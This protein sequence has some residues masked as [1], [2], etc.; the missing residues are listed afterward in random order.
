MII[1]IGNY[2]ADK[3]ESMIRFANTLAVGLK[4]RG[5]DVQ[6]WN[7]KVVLGSC[8]SPTSLIGKWI[9]YV[10][11]W[12]LFPIFIRYRIWKL[13]NKKGKKWFHI[14]D[15]SNS[16]YLS[17]LPSHFASITCHDV[18]AIKA[19]LGYLGF[20]QTPSK[21]GKVY[22]KWILRN[23][24]NAENIATV[25]KF[26]LEQLKEITPEVNTNHCNWRVIL[27]PFNA[28]FFPLSSEQKREVLAKYNISLPERFLLH[29]GSSLPRKNRSLLLKMLVS[30]GN[31]YDGCVCYAGDDLDP[32]LESIINEFELTKRVIFV[33]K[34]DHELLRCLYNSCEAFIFPSFNEGFGWPVIEA[35][36]C[37]VPVIASNVQPMP[38]VGGKG[39]IYADPNSENDFAKTF[40]EIENY[41]NLI[42]QG[43]K[44]C[45]RFSNSKIIDEYLHLFKIEIR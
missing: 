36:A 5:L 20:N 26:T 44:N 25:S 1:L 22:Q 13:R 30:L 18:I 41:E 9:G 34:P 6:V 23:L 14:C 28:D 16:P 38:E 33:K 35:Q 43:F 39:A 24:K 3:Q 32:E 29:V 11:K 37:G 42:A 15:H 2:P 8:F 21:F 31:R 10:D 7:P 27:N 4:N 19:G 45:E 17:F 40:L 12:L